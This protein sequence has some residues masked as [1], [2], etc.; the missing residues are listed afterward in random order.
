MQRAIRL[1]DQIGKAPSQIGP[2]GRKNLAKAVRPG[3]EQNAHPEPRRSLSHCD[4][5][6]EISALASLK[7]QTSTLRG[8]G[9]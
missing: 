8:G 2:E 1:S 4:D 7:H 6:I 3:I 9:R 5:S